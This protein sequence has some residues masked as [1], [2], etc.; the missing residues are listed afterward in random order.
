MSART[1]SAAPPLLDAARTALQRVFGYADFR[2][3]QAEVIDAV[4]AGAPVL[5]VMPTGSGKSMCYQLPALVEGGLTIIVSP[6]IALMRDQV[7]QMRTLGVAAA[8]LNSMSS[9]AETENAWQSLHSGELRL[10]FLSPE[11]LAVRE[12]THALARAGVRRLA[13]DEAHCVS[14]WG[15]DFR[16]E[17]RALGRIA[18]ALGNVQ[19]VAL[20]A[21]AD[22]RTRAEIAERLFTREPQIFVHSFD[23]PNIALAF[24]PKDQPRRQIA[25]FLERHRGESGILYCSSRERTERLTEWLR[26]KG[27]TP[28]PTTPAWTAPGATSIRTVSCRKTR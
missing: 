6:L 18:E 13:I 15:H 16:P 11:R 12:L 21:T 25:D 3:G 28:S 26:G 23:R 7:Q 9:E 14:E 10:L 27:A 17:Y 19:V 22:K 5:A 2:P 24:A 4:L 20:T 1:A 8:T